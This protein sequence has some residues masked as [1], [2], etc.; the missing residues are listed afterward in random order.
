MNHAI[1][2]NPFQSQYYGWSGYLYYNEGKFNESLNEYLKNIE[3]DPVSKRSLE[4]FY[5]YFRLNKDPKALESLQQYIKVV[6]DTLAPK[7]LKMVRNAFDSSG[8]TGVLNLMIELSKN[9]TWSFSFW[10][11]AHLYAML[12]KK[13]LALDCLEKAFKNPPLEFFRINNEYDF[14]PLHSE[15]RFQKIILKMELSKY[16]EPK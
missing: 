14:Q 12:G 16:Q 6:S 7:Y 4:C 1:E 8:V 2:L 5:N 10:E 15:P 11:K 3:L 13:D 9:S